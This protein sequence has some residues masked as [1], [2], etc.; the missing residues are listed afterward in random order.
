MLFGTETRHEVILQD[1]ANGTWP[2]SDC[3]ARSQFLHGTH[4]SPPGDL[5]LR[6]VS[7]PQPPPHA[8]RIA[9]GATESLGSNICAGH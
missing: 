9:N 5:T 8:T 4:G 1:F 6:Y 3:Y 2:L 7:F